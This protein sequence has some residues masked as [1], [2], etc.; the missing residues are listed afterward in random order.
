M[1]WQDNICLLDAIL[2]VCIEIIWW[3]GSAKIDGLTTNFS[4]DTVCGLKNGL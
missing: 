4:G 3:I 2:D 1:S